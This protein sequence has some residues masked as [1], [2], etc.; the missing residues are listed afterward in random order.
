MQHS[1]F[2]IQPFDKGEFDELYD[3]VIELAVKA[4]DAICL[5]A[6]KIL[7]ATP[8]LDKIRDSIENASVILAEV[9]EN[10]PNVY[11]EA[12]W[13]FARG[14]PIF[15]LWDVS[16]RPE[17]LPFDISGNAGIPYDQSKQ[18]W[19][20]K[21][22]ETLTENIKFELLQLSE[23]RPIA[24]SN[25]TIAELL[26]AFVHYC[27]KNK[28]PRTFETYTGYINH[29]T[30]YMG[31]KLNSPASSLKSSQILE[32]VDS[33]KTWKASYTRGAIILIQRIYNWGVSRNYISENPI[34]G[35][36]KPK[37]SKR[38]NPLTQEIYEKILSTVKKEDGFYDL[39]RFAWQVDI[40][41]EEI[42]Y[43]ETKH[44]DFIKKRIVMP[45]GGARG[46]QKERSIPLND[47][48]M[49]IV[50]KLKKKNPTEKLFL[51]NRGEPWSKY[52]ICNRLIRSSKSIKKDKPY[53][54]LSDFRNGAVYS[55]YL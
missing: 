30:R 36:K 28:K 12:G 18:G 27:N 23:T 17:G 49:V 11:F 40:R 25:C 41:P 54:A 20:K 16:R 35:I 3:D 26:K 43:L 15:V 4:A 51:N 8:P 21:L 53:Y 13:A 6:D 10:N 7:G 1:C 42:R 44:I 24:E 48:A 2:V 45:Q 39:L 32:W 33:Q 46:G 55:L 14:K 50:T 52:A 47:T 29:F 9:T 31:D 19:R 5:R 34:K 38:N 37:A 22:R